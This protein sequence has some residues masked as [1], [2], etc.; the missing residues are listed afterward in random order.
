MRDSRYLQKRRG[1]LGPGAAFEIRNAINYR[2][3]AALHP[4]RAPENA[5][6]SGTFVTVP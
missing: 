2:F 4:Q 1:E 3:P 5:L 6:A